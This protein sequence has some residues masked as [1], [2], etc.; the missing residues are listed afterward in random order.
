LANREGAPSIGD[1][2]LAPALTPEAV[3]RRAAAGEVVLDVRSG[4]AF[5][6]GHVPD[7]VNVDLHGEF[8][9]WAGALLPP[10]LPIVLVA[11]DRAR[12]REA[13]VRLARVGLETVAGHLD[14]GPTAW[15]RT[16][17][18]LARVDQMPVAELNA[19]VSA[20]PDELQVVDVRRPREYAAGHV[21]GATPL[22]LDRLD[23][24]IARLDPARPLALVCGSG[25]RSSTAASLLR[26]QGFGAL[27]NIVGG[28]TAWAAAGY[29]MERT[30]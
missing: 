1:R 15:E 21:P 27:H 29:P 23:A 30:G 12:V 17:R 19:R 10:A 4:G 5:G 18:A 2:P 20:A 9:P 28:T 14:G 25:Y 11:D 13:T 24:G 7:S 3:E 16:G 26:R 6:S 8:A 22:P